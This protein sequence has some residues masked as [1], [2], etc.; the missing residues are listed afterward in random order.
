M[1]PVIGDILF[2]EGDAMTGLS[3]R[4]AQTAPDRRVTVSPGGTYGQSKDEM[5]I[6][7]A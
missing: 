6:P 7:A 4:V 2:E 1:R 3:Q 5:R